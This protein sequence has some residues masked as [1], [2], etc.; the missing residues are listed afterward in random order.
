MRRLSINFSVLQMLDGRHRDMHSYIW[1]SAGCVQGELQV[2]GASGNLQPKTWH[3]P[4]AEKWGPED[5]YAHWMLGSCV[6]RVGAAGTWVSGSCSSSSGMHESLLCSSAQHFGQLV[7]LS[8]EAGEEM[9]CTLQAGHP[10]SMER[11]GCEQSW[12]ILSS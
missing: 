7:P 6:P 3:R 9:M 12:R 11:Q 8:E 1:R 5:P 4:Q 10:A 2:L